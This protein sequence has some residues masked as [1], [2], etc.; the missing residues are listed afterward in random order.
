[1]TEQIDWNKATEYAAALEEVQK[2]RA[3]K[4]KL[5][6]PK[7]LVQSAK[8]IEHVEDPELGIICFGHLTLDDIDDLNKATSNE[9]RTKITLYKI[10]NK[11]YPDLTLDDVRS[12]PLETVQKLLR[13]VAKPF[14][15][16]RP[17]QKNSGKTSFIGSKAAQK[18]SE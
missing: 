16:D 3:E 8:K 11:A 5:F 14:L 18:R 15:P 10:L 6:D 2:A 13:I 4:A 12:F 1:M 17:L 7:K 9:E